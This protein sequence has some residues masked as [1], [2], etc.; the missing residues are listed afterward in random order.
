M[1]APTL[2]ALAGEADLVSLHTPLDATTRGMIGS[3]FFGAAKPLTLVNTSHAVVDIADLLA[4][5]DAGI[6]RG[7]ALDVLPEEPRGPVA[8]SACH[9]DARGVLFRRGGEGTAAQGRAEHR[10]VV[11]HG[12]AGNDP[13]RAPQRRRK[14]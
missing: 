10:D 1:R 9:P 8:G 11:P 14:P 4:A 7:A 5:L 6:L 2:E 13:G 3:R 12:P